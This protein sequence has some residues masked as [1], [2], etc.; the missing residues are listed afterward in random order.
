MFVV[1][2]ISIKPIKKP[3]ITFG[4]WSSEGETRT[5]GLSIMSAAL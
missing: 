5:R 2:K 1:L 4:A 3:R